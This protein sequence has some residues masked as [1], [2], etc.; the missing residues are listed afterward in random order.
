MKAKS[1][2]PG[3][4]HVENG[5]DVFTALGAPNAD[6]VCT[7]SNDAWQIADCEHFMSY[8]GGYEYE[9]SSAEQRANARL[10]AAAPELY[11]ALQ[12]MVEKAVRQN[13][14]DNYPEQLAQARAALAKA[15]QP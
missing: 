3:P 5:K 7:E 11:A 8:I 15:V 2:T 10:I 14:N 1:F 6:G 9:L 13:W 4:W 12:V